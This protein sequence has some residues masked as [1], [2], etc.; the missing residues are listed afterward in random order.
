MP[1]PLRICHRG[2]VA[3]VLASGAAISLTA[4]SG[5]IV[6]A[7]AEPVTDTL[8]PTTTEAVPTTVPQAT[9]TVE[10]PTLIQTTVA[11]SGALVATASSTLLV[12]D[13]AHQA[14]T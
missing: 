9:A 11:P 2:R 8:V 3:V 1:V 14:R 6:P 13:L 4:L 5:G 7:L 12:I 10:A